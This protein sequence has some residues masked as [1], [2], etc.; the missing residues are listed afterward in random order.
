MSQYNRPAASG[1][2][3]A[4]ADTGHAGAPLRASGGAWRLA[5]KYPGGLEIT[6]GAQLKPSQAAAA[7]AVRVDGPG[8][9]LACILLARAAGR[10]SVDCLLFK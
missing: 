7:P 1:L 9:V 10:A 4:L 3:K 5:V 2:A 6:D 8:C